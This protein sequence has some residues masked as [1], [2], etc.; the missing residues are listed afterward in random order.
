MHCE[1]C[2]A[3]PKGEVLEAQ[4]NNSDWND[5]VKYYFYKNG[6]EKHTEFDE[7][8]LCYDCFPQVKN[9]Y[10]KDLSLYNEG[11]DRY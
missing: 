4:S 9:V 7:V 8:F 11:V 3:T 10:V 6:A 2:K 5:W 1:N